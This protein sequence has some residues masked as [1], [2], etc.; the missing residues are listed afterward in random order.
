M[1]DISAARLSKAYLVL[2]IGLFGV[3]VAANNIFDYGSNFNFVQHVM[4]MDTTFP[5]NDLMWRAIPSPVFHHAVYWLIIAG[6]MLTGLLCIWG[7]VRLMKNS[8]Q[9]RH[10]FVDAKRTAI[11]GLTL[12]IL[13]WFFGFMVVAAEWFLMWQSQQWNGVDA[14]FRFVM[15]ISVVLIYLTQQDPD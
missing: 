1:I 9:P 10:L 2:L 3:L 7:S 5:D 4:L 8:R 13:V 15:C 11:L 14:A 6:E 12:G